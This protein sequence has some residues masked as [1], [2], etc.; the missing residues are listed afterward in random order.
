MCVC[1]VES[2]GGGERGRG[3]EEREGRKGSTRAAEEKA[4]TRRSL[5]KVVLTSPKPTDAILPQRAQTIAFPVAPR[6]RKQRVLAGKR[7]KRGRGERRGSARSRGDGAKIS[8]DVVAEGEKMSNERTKRE[9]KAEERAEKRR[10]KTRRDQRQRPPT[11]SGTQQGV[12]QCY[13]VPCETQDVPEKRSLVSNALTAVSF[14]LSLSRFTTHS[15][16]SR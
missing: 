2:G 8:L 12:Q 10:E 11:T 4:L 9:R 13:F 14:F 5:E 1:A 15:D 7:G 6:L 16:T 3:R